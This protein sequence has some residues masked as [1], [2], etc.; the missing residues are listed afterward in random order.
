MW[1]L[2]SSELGRLRRKLPGFL[3]SVPEVLQSLV[4][5]ELSVQ[6]PDLEAHE[7]Q[8]DVQSVRLLPGLREN[9]HVVL[10]GSGEQ[11][12]DANR[13]KSGRDRSVGI[14]REATLTGHHRLAVA[15]P[16]GSD[17]H[18]LLA[19]VRSHVRVAVH[20]DPDWLLQRDG[21]EVFHLRTSCY[22][23]KDILNI[24]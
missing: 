24:K 13:D 12:W 4:L 6:L 1:P 17:P 16:V 14:W 2:N 21:R 11:S 8:Q 23:G 3:A 9:H 19:Q 10:E 18:K 15:L 20:E 5:A 7:S 22:G